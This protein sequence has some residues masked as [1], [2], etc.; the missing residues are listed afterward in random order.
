[1]GNA[2]KPSVL[3]NQFSRAEVWKASGKPWFY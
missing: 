2:G 1:M 3:L